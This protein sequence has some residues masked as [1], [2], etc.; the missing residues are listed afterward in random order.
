MEK[1]FEKLS[2]LTANDVIFVEVEI[3]VSSVCRPVIT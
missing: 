2:F 1:D 3:F